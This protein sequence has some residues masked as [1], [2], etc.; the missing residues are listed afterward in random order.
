MYW[1]RDENGFAAD[2]AKPFMSYAIIEVKLEKLKKYY[3]VIQ[4]GFFKI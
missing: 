3:R 2:T 1:S 4:G